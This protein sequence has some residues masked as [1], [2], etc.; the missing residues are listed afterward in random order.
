MDTFFDIF[1]SG[2]FLISFSE[3]FCFLEEEE[4][5]RRVQKGESSFF[6]SRKY[7]KLPS[8]ADESVPI[9]TIAC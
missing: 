1:L 9:L 5:K 3:L 6:L 2:H 8:D 4:M 7:I